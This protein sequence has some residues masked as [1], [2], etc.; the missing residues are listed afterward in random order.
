MWQ[1]SRKIDGRNITVGGGAQWIGYDASARKVRSWS[2]EFSGAFGEGSWSRD[3]KVWTVKTTMT[4]RDGK[5]ASATHIITP[6]DADTFTFESKD[7]TLDGKELPPLKPI[8][9]KRQK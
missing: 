9:M 3:G 2:F 4:L 8:R 7:R 5:K 6:I 1:R